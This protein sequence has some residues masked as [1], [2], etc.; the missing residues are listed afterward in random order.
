MEVPALTSISPEIL[1]ELKRG[2][3]RTLEV[4]SAHNVITIANVQPGDHIFMTSVDPED[5]SPGDR[6]IMAD[7]LTIGV[8]MKRIIEYAR[9]SHYEERER[10]AVRIQ[11]RYC[12]ESTIKAVP[13]RTPFSP[14]LVDVVRVSCAHAG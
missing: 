3:P 2:L 12:A 11:L 7:V 9:G 8:S 4:Q 5:L 10:T 6:G 14:T 13:D 1:R